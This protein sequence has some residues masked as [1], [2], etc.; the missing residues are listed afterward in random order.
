MHDIALQCWSVRFII[1]ALLIED[2]LK[3]TVTILVTV[4]GVLIGNQI[5]WTPTTRNFI[6]T[7][8]DCAVTVL[9]TSQITIGHT[10][11]FQSV[12]VFT[13][14]FRVS[15]KV[16]VTLKLAVY[17]QSVRLGAK[18]LEAHDQKLFF[19]LNPCGHIGFAFVKCTCRTC[20]MLLK[21]LPCTLHGSPLSVQA[22]QSGSCLS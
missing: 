4:D 20:S 6:T 16:R 21:I 18:S 12:T 9:H 2:D 11:S 5:Y 17:C 15:I 22:L 19:R 13:S 8:K 1:S 14:Q 10:R 3:H 7:S